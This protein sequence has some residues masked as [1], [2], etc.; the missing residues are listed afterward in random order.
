MAEREKKLRK[1]QDLRAQT[2]YVSKSAL[3]GILSWAK[4]NGEL[5]LASSKHMREASRA[6]FAGANAYGPVLV[7]KEV[8]MADGSKMSLPFLNLHSFLHAGYSAGGALFELLKDVAGPAGLALYSD[9][10]CPGNALAA[11]TPRKCWVVYA[12]IVQ[13]HRHLQ[14]EKKLGSLCVA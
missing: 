5:P 9:E 3:E 10:V 14:N 12:G 8:L 7:E 6:T 4:Q 11:S 13:S 2:P 1:L